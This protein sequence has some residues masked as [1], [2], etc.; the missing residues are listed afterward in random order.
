MIE[1]YLREINGFLNS[2]IGYIVITVFLTAIGLL[3]WVF[4]E[5][6]VLD[7]GYA[8]METLFSLGP[9]VFVF[10]IPAITMRM[11]A[12]E[13]KSGTL[14]LLFTRPVSGVGILMGKYLAGITL[15]VISII[16]TLI[17]YYS[18]S[19]LGNPP[20]NLDTAGIM[21]SYVGLVLLGAVFTSIGTF[22]STLTENQIVAFVIAVFM[23]FLIYSGFSSLA[24]IDIWS[25][26]SLVVE[27]L[28]I[29][30]H[31]TAMSKGLI[32]SRDLI[33][34][35]SVII[36]MLSLTNLVLESRKW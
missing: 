23:C 19:Q 1:I 10:L 36:I 30:Y 9:Y 16:P 21:G 4:P 20:G 18:L 33:Y 25:G 15:V 3:M 27:K 28:G 35:I 6:N 26:T 7:Y 12:E 14:E 17:Y 32:D 22:A 29:L 2:L 34:F 5:T 11:F 8:D 31:Y 13:K 24:Q